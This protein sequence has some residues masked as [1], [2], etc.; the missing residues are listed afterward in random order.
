[1]TRRRWSWTIG[2]LVLASAGC[3]AG[4]PAPSAAPGNQGTSGVAGMATPNQ[5]ELTAEIHRLV[6]AHRVDAGLSALQ[7]REE[8]A[9]IAQRHSSEMARGGRPFGHQHFDQRTAEIQEILPLGQ[10][11]E[12]VAYD[13]RTGPSLPALVVQGWL[14]SSGHR[15][16]IEG[17]FGLTGIGVAE[18]PAGVRFFTQIFVQPR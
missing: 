15:R 13:S 9:A 6:N 1:M 8:I 11:A 3:A 10:I 17:E 2:A 5:Q 14:S 4:G 16:N 18:S 7:W 12:N